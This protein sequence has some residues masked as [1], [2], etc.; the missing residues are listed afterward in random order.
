MDLD[1]VVTRRRILEDLR[2]L[3]VESGDIIMSHEW[4]RIW[5]VALNETMSGR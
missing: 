5:L 2:A 1:R 4:K 3:G